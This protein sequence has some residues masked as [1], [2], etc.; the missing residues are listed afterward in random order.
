MATFVAQPNYWV[1][2]LTSNTA[3]V[4]NFKFVVEIYVDSNKIV[5]LKQPKNTNGAAHITY[6]K[7]VKDYIEITHKHSNSTSGMVIPYTS[8]HQ[9]PLNRTEAGGVIKDFPFSKNIKSYQTITFKF[10]EEFSTSASG[11]VQRTAT[12]TAT[13]LDVYKINYANEWE[14]AMQLDEELYSMETS[15]TERSFLTE[16]PNDVYT[17]TSTNDQKTLS[18]INSQ[19][20]GFDTSQG[21]ISY[22]FF[23]EKPVNKFLSSLASLTN[24]VGRIDIPNN[25]TY[26]SA[27]PSAVPDDSSKLIFIGAG[28]KN[29]DKLYFPDLGGY[30]MNSDVKYYSITY[31]TSTFNDESFINKSPSF[32]KQG[33]RIE[34][35]AVGTIDYVALGATVNS[36][37]QVFIA[38]ATSS[39]GI[40]SYKRRHYRGTSKDYIFEVI[41]SGDCD[42]SQFVEY[43]LGWKNKFGT[44]DYYMFDGK[45]V[46]S[47]DYS[48]K[49]YVDKAA[50]TWDSSVFEINPYERGIKQIVEGTRKTKIS[51]RFL[52][53]GYNSYFNSMLM[54]NEVVLLNP[55]NTGSDNEKETPVPINIISKSIEYK[56]SANEKLVSYS[57]EFEYAHKLKTRI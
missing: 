35:I 6:E 12:T 31:E 36:N 44:W 17:L 56:T 5:T 30:E 57:F 33:D 22:K 34:I 1:L 24:Y 25:S 52:S 3:P 42:Q 49:D 41:N 4:Y 51:T 38:N 21:V 55:V 18:F 11:D 10:Y 2:T 39:S 46:E 23:T 14:D 29:V 26:G 45:S 8:I 40:G 37:G 54:S 47:I 16:L 19:Q 15:A 20:G 32:I 43:S 28:G 50:G 27:L 7:I 48:R 9:I 13:D 53:E